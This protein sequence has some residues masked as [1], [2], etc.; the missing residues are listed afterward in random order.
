MAPAGRDAGMESMEDR[1]MDGWG[2]G[3]AAPP[4]LQ[5]PPRTLT[6]LSIIIPVSEASSMA[7]RTT[8]DS[9]TAQSSPDWELCIVDDASASD[10]GSQVR[11]LASRDRR[12]RVARR[13]R[14]G[15]TAEA[16]NDALAVSSGDFVAVVEPG[17]LLVKGTVEA[18]RRTLDDH[19]EADFCYRDEAKITPSGRLL[20]AFYKPDWSP[21]RMRSQLYTG[22]LS[23]IR[24]TLALQLGG[25][26]PA[27]DACLDR[28]LG[29]RVSENTRNIVH[30]AEVLYLRRVDEAPDPAEPDAATLDSRRRAIA[31]Q[32][33][34][35][36]IEGVVEAIPSIGSF[37]VRRRL[38]DAP[39][40]SIVIPTRG[41][42]SGIQGVRR[43]HVLHALSSVIE[44]STYPSFGILLVADR[45]TPSAVID[46]IVDLCGGRLRLE[47]FDGPFNFSTK[48][49]AGVAASSGDVV[50]LVNDDV[51]VLTP[52]WIETLT[53]FVQEPDCGLAGCKLLTAFE[54]LQ[55]GGVVW[56]PGAIVHAYA[57]YPSDERGMADLVRIARAA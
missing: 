6:T 53:G 20:N 3:L 52:D 27:F 44:R 31:E 13:T 54:T 36:G 18:V 17:D 50:I 34:R 43:S 1:R 55:H 46:G 57:T 7:L 40:V 15:G 49:N 39:D 2:I 56:T 48:C 5:G 14:P 41:S 30:I 24:R 8:I 35:V 32:C 11:A 12:V 37:R 29:L 28:E 10:L 38:H 21:E 23:A 4:L 26:R 9:V 22:R 19:P 45:E 51:D 42:A 33:D 47:W 25:Y 16:S